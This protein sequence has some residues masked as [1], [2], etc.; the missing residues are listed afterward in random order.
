VVVA[1]TAHQR[2]AADARDRAAIGQDRRD[3]APAA[4]GQPGEAHHAERRQDARDRERACGMAAFHA[5]LEQ[6]AHRLRH[7]REDAD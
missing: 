3:L 7:D 2:Q 6:V 5:A 1:R 4:I